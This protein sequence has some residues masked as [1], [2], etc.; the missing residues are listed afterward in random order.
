MQ[1]GVYLNAQHPAEDDPA[2]RFAETVEQVRLIRALGF[3]A[4]WGGEHHAPPGFHYFPLLPF[5]QRLAAEADGLALGTNLI[6]LPLHNPVEVAEIGAFLDVISGGRFLLGVGLG[7][8]PEE[9]ALF[10][11]PIA[12]RVSRLVEGIEVIRRLWTENEV[13]DPD[14]PVNADLAEPWR[15]YAGPAVATALYA[16]VLYFAFLA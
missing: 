16:A 11:V 6:L 14:D 7:Y 15:M 8:R 10:G 9:F 4:I 3:D 1:L 13:Y 12:E 2:R 5:L